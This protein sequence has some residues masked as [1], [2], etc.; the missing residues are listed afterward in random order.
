MFSHTHPIHLHDLIAPAKA[1][2]KGWPASN[3]LCVM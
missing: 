3:N 1:R 2:E